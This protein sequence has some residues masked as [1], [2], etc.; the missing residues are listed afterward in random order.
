MSG[1]VRELAPPSDDRS[2]GIAGSDKN[3]SSARFFG[4]TSVKDSFFLGPDVIDGEEGGSGRGG[5]GG[6]ER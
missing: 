4:D 3:P 1:R 5:G 6:R 2:F